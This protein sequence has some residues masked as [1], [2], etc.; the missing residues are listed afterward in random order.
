[1]VGGENVIDQDLLDP[2]SLDDNSIKE[3]DNSDM[4]EKFK[5][6]TYWHWFD[7]NP[8]H[9]GLSLGICDGEATA[10]ESQCA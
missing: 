5:R 7:W 10:Q 8:N 3:S 1:M 4:P 2:A 9:Q 6:K